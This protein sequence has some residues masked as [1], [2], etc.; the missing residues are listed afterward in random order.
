M[1]FTNLTPVPGAV[2][3]PAE[4]HA[5][6][7]PRFPRLLN[8][9]EAFRVLEEQ[10]RPLGLQPELYLGSVRIVTASKKFLA[11]ERRH[12]GPLSQRAQEYLDFVRK[13]AI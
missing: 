7:D 12:S 5:A 9:E 1:N 11:R 6:L 13:E 4:L 3:S 8:F 10:C 2:Y